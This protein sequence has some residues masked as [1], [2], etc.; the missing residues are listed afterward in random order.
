VELVNHPDM[1]LDVC[2]Q[3]DHRITTEPAWAKAEGYSLDRVSL[4][5]EKTVPRPELA[6]E[7]AVDERE[8]REMMR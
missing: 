1:L 4:P 6:A 5:S 7:A 2:A 3:C 8:W